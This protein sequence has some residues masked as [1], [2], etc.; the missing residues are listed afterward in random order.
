MRIRL[1]PDTPYCYGVMAIDFIPKGAWILRTASNA[2]IDAPYDL[3][4]DESGLP[5]RLCLSVVSPW[6]GMFGDGRARIMLGP[7]RFVNHD[8]VPNTEVSRV[9]IIHNSLTHVFVRCL[10]SRTALASC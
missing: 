7:L 5:D 4:D 9:S 3:D 2:A 10:A 6:K 8:C 1:A